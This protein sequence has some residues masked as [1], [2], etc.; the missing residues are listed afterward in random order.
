MSRI[1]EVIL[2]EA[3]TLLK[4]RMCGPDVA[5]RV[6]NVP[7]TDPGRMW[8]HGDF[9][10]CVILLSADVMRDLHRL[11]GLTHFNRSDLSLDDHEC[12]YAPDLIGG[13][14]ILLAPKEPR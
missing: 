4:A 5:A 10:K 14:R 11:R 2:H 9:F 7:E 1:D 3:R 6:P 12:I 8:K 13:Y